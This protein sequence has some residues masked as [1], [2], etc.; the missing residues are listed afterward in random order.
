MRKIQ[1]AV[2][3]AGLLSVTGAPAQQ[4][5]GSPAGKGKCWV[6]TL[7]GTYGFYRT[8]VNVDGPLE[9]VGV[10]FYDGQGNSHSRQTINRNGELEFDVELTGTYEVDADCGVIG[11]H[12]GDEAYRGAV[13][14]DGKTLYF[15][16]E[17]NGAVIR[18]LATR[19]QS[20]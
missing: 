1:I 10:A 12:D 17:N 13:V 11:Y 15:I 7:K 3:L 19:T 14:D 18:G 16:S 6:A 2:V 8:G 4:S 5:A 9:A 20:K